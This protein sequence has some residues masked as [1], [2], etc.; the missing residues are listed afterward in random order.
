MENNE[1]L[2]CIKCNK[3]DNVKDDIY[4]PNC[5]YEVDS[6]YCSNK[7][8]PANEEPDDLVAFP[9]DACFCVC[10]GEKTQYYKDGFIE[11]LIY[12]N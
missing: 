3:P 5:G 8:C 4:C 12:E 11:P 7:D 10:C 2:K 9:A 6:N 1:F